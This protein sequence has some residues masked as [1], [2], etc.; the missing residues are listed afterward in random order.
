MDPD[1]GTHALCPLFPEEMPGA[2]NIY[3]YAQVAKRTRFILKCFVSVS[4]YWAME[5]IYWRLM[6]RLFGY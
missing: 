6:R 1:F 4:E 2:K 3:M 5:C